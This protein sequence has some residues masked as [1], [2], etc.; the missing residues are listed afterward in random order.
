MQKLASTLTELF[1]VCSAS[2]TCAESYAVR[3][4]A[5]PSVRKRSFHT[6]AMCVRCRFG[7]MK[8][9]RATMSASASFLS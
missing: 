5:S 4:S 8:Q 7:V 2:R 6:H 9:H 3:I 1:C